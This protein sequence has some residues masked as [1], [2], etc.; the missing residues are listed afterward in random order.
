MHLSINHLLPVISQ[1]SPARHSPSLQES[2][3]GRAKTVII[4]TVSPHA[5]SYE[6]TL[7]TIDYAHRAKHIKNRPECNQK[8][9]QRAY[10]KDLSGQVR[11]L[12]LCRCE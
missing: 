5:S 4:A 2:L 8:L 12:W 1:S 10:V 3:G 7:S 9:T 11:C 6:E